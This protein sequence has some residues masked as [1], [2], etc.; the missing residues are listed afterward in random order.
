MWKV[1]H[2]VA[3]TTDSWAVGKGLSSGFGTSKSEKSYVDRPSG[4]KSEGL[5]SADVP[6]SG[7]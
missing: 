7:H 5:Y 3:T 4:T 1:A 2:S 6:T